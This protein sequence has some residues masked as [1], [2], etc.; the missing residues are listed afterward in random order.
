MGS[1]RSLARANWK[2]TRKRLERYAAELRA[3]D[4]EVRLPD[5]WETPPSERVAQ[6]TPR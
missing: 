4:A 1:S 2:R 3:H 6:P 5:N